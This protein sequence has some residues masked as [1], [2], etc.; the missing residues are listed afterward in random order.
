MIIMTGDLFI[1]KPNIRLGDLPKIFKKAE[2]VVSNFE[3]VLCSDSHA[4][5]PDKSAILQFLQK[6]F[7][8]YISQIPTRS[9]F[10]LGNNH[11]HDLGKMGLEDTEQYLKR[12]EDILQTGV[13]EYRNVMNPLIVTCD[14]KKIALFCVS[15]DDPEV[16]SILATEKEKGVLDYLDP[17]II[18]V[19]S[20]TKKIVDHFI[21]IPHWGREYVD[22][23]S[24]HLRKAAYKWIDAGADLVVGHHPHIIQGKEMYKNKS[25][26]YSI[27]NFIFPEFVTK[28]GEH[29]KWEASNNRSIMLEIKC[30]DQLVIKE[31]GLLFDQEKLKPEIDSRSLTEFVKKSEYLNVTTTSLKQYY[32]IWEKNYV[33]N[34]IKNYSDPKILFMILFPASKIISRAM[35]NLYR[36][37]RKIFK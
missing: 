36:I 32:G 13:G 12:N 17:G 29:K 11:I 26:Y 1:G 3:N 19:I 5:R 23:P 21:M 22:Y 20:K 18:E 34:A 25:I 4:K 8:H 24:P 27:G 15:T 35:Y 37:F 31:T 2:Y 10:T 33:Y 14:N 9:I 6:D 30:D 28:N 7:E 16:M